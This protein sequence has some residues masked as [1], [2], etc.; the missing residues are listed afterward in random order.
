MAHGIFAGAMER[1]LPGSTVT[2][3]IIQACPECCIEEMIW[4]D[5]ES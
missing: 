1:V 5:K 3:E 4:E 2:L